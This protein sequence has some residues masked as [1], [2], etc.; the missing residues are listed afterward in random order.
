V[1]K[2]KQSSPSQEQFT[3][4][5]DQSAFKALDLLNFH[6][7]LRAKPAARVLMDHVHSLDNESKLQ[8]TH[9]CESLDSSEKL[10]QETLQQKDGSPVFGIDAKVFDDKLRVEKAMLGLATTTSK[11]YES[12]LQYCVKTLAE[13]YRCRF[14]FIG[15]LNRDKTQVTTQAVW[16]G[17]GYSENFEY[18]LAGSACEDIANFTKDIIPRHAAQ[19]YPHDELLVAMGI[20]SFFGVPIV[21]EETGVIGLVAVMDTEPMRVARFARAYS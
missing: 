4:S 8:L 21:H 2:S 20:D 16:N 11:D 15:L 10:L 5:A 18:A 6:L 13:F 14:A 19:R 3:A 7:C 12:F 9:L 17:D 1:N